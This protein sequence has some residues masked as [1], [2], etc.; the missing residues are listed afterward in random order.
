MYHVRL[1][2]VETN[3]VWNG[4][5]TMWD[6]FQTLDII[7]ENLH[8]HAS[9]TLVAYADVCLCTHALAYI[10]RLLPMYVS[11]GPLWYFISKNI[12]LLI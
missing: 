10:R 12:F 5:Q 2:I 1:Y 4:S 6:S 9:E 7:A 11:R 8:F 3:G